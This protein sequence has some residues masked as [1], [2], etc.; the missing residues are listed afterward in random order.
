M[1]PGCFHPRNMDLSVNLSYD[2]A[3]QWGRDVSI[4]EIAV[5]GLDGRQQTGFNGAGM[6]PSQKSG[7]RVRGAMFGVELQWGR[8]VSI[9]E[10]QSSYSPFSGHGPLQ[11]GRDVSIPE[12][13]SQ[14][15]DNRY[16]DW[17]QWGRDV[18]IPEITWRSGRSA[19][20]L[21]FNGAGMF[22]SQKSGAGLAGPVNLS[23]LQW[24]RD[25]SIPE[26]KDAGGAG[27]R[28]GG[29]SMGPGCFHPRNV[30]ENTG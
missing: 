16:R 1:G 8:D 13:L 28:P 24:G 3:L 5:S 7:V 23:L 30:V 9:P 2:G 18:S 15:G 21:C 19:G 22:P 10:M 27:A 29:A 4:P 6:F 14:T 17:L 26:M 12:I 20:T 11:W 25:V